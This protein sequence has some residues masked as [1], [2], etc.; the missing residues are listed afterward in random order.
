MVSNIPVGKLE[1]IC[2]YSEKLALDLTSVI[3][4]S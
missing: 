1:S 3:K 2:V 4:T